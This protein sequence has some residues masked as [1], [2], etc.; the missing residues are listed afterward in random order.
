MG[1]ISMNFS[2]KE[3]DCK[4]GTPVPAKLKPNIKKL[5]IEV[6]QPLR[7]Y[8]KRPIHIASGYRTPA[9]NAACG[10]V[11]NSQHLLGTAADIQI[12]GLKPSETQNIVRGFMIARK[13]GGGVG[14]YKTFTHI[15]I[16]PGKEVI[17]WDKRK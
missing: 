6:L 11:K 5:V 15:D 1:D 14:W 12:E 2:Y 10:G 16:R 4:D 17:F 8:F 13:K 7:D 3:F 9:Y